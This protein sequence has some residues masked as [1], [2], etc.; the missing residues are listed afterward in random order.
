MKVMH[1]V[2]RFEETDLPDDLAEM[3]RLS[4]QIEQIAELSKTI[5]ELGKWIHSSQR[6]LTKVEAWSR[7][8]RLGDA[9]FA[10]DIFTDLQKRKVGRSSNRYP[11]YV[12]V[13]ELMLQG[14]NVSIGIARQKIRPPLA[15]GEAPGLKAGILRLKKLLQKHAPDLVSRYEEL[16]PDRAKKVNG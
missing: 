3:A 16:H 8:I 9:E 14:R 7:A 11:T 15:K 1:E 2:R 13:F 10:P 6:P 12:R 5:N 4:E